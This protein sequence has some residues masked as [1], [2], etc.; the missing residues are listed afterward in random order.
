MEFSARVCKDGRCQS[1]NEHLYGVY[2]KSKTDAKMLCVESIIKI[3]SLLH[4]MGKNTTKSN[5]YQH[6]VGNGQIW[7]G[8]KPVHS[9]A[10]AR[11]IYE[12]F[13]QSENRGNIISKY[14]VE[15]LAVSIMSHHGL[16]DCL[17]LVSGSEKDNNRFVQKIFNSEYNYDEAVKTTFSQ[18][19]TKD[20]IAELFDKSLNEMQVVL[21]KVIAAD[22]NELDFQLALLE[23]MILS[24]LVNADHSD[25]AG[26]A[27]GITIT[28][29]YGTKEIW[30]QCSNYIEN[31]I[32]KF[33]KE[34]EI[35][36]IRSEISD[37]AYEFAGNNE[38]IVKL[39]VP[40]GGGKTISSLRYAVN[41]ALKHNKSRIIYAAPFNSILEQNA[42]EF[43]KFLPDTI[44]V[45]Q[46]Y[47]DV[48]TYEDNSPKK[49]YT[50]SWGSLFI[51]TSMVQFLNTLFDGK[52]T[53][54]RRMRG[55]INSVI[56]LDEVQSIPLE[57][58]S[59]FNTA[60]NF[61]TKVCGCT[62]VLCTAT[63]PAL[64]KV[65]HNICFGNNCEI[66]NNFEE[67]YDKLKRTEIIDKLI[68][69]GYSFDGT[70]EFVYDIAKENNSVL[71][72][73]NTK[74][75]AYEIYKKVKQNVEAENEEFIVVHLSTNMC[76]QH[77]K[78]VI[79]QIK[80]QLNENKKVICISTQLIEAGVDISFCSVIR[81]L[82]GLDSIIQAAGRCNRNAEVATGKVYVININ[83]ENLS[84][85]K[86]ISEG[87]KITEAMMY[88]MRSDKCKFDGDI[89]S[90][91]A[92][93]HYYN[94]FY[95]SFESQMDFPVN[96]N[97]LNGITIYDL[98]TENSKGMDIY[99]TYHKSPEVDLPVI[100]QA[101][102]T[103]GEKFKAIDNNSL[104]VLVPYGK[105]RELIEII[106][107][108][109]YGG[110][111]NRLICEIQ[112]Y[113]IGL[114]Q[115]MKESSDIIVYNECV[116]I[117][118]LRERYYNED[119]GFERGSNED[120]YVLKKG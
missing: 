70:A 5:E 43:I 89:S 92:I 4:D 101:F 16:F 83:E 79:A 74:K 37:I 97:N 85:L 75:A 29:E 68:P 112:K 94:E 86:S 10:G 95:K 33:G 22:K 45:L 20:E 113:S 118:V 26:F 105:G 64:D 9:A 14:L 39:S 18:T 24:I 80:N 110:D 71:C 60:I 31:K 54:L 8:N 19:I 11:Y 73:V 57:C 46:H 17:S 42:A 30:K 103:A 72:I 111:I 109:F 53:S 48:V 88:C 119:T 58:I 99:K 84:K 93:N 117:Y 76:P 3:V 66:I 34:R 65:R 41:H 50:E 21:S 36:C 56:I 2:N 23:R 115:Y 47:G 28:N 77:R 96:D 102:K 40:T 27:D 78:N 82:S 51:V 67:Y 6:T 116:G 100:R 7:K 55:L 49:Y 106:N 107:S 32:Q 104:S 98:L 59:M 38:N 81:S 87:R 44:N 13:F 69:G 63:Q 91:K 61:L 108:D 1:V 114:P 90:L 120:I 12:T 52:I 62:I 25:A 15:I 35:D